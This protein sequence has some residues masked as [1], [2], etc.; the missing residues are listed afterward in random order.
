MINIIMERRRL[1]SSPSTGDWLKVCHWMPT[2]ATS[3]RAKYL[4]PSPKAVVDMRDW[5]GKEERMEVTLLWQVGW[6]TFR[7]RW[8]LQRETPTK[9]SPSPPE[10]HT[11]FHTW[12]HFRILSLCFGISAGEDQSWP[13]RQRHQW[14]RPHWS[15]NAHMHWG[16]NKVN[17]LP[18]THTGGAIRDTPGATALH[19]SA[20]GEA[21]EVGD[22]GKPQCS[23]IRVSMN[24]FRLKR[25]RTGALLT[26]MHFSKA[27]ILSWATSSRM[28]IYM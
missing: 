23:S 13:V 8:C 27:V 5:K 4:E 10:I 14:G 28:A 25:A 12:K 2:P 17:S 22:K 16:Q 3:Y 9:L 21:P 26:A 18:Y 20:L 1:K 19:C 11:H 15:A 6:D 24:Q 7:L